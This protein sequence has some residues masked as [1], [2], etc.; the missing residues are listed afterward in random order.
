[1][2]KQT[3]GATT[4]DYGTF[5]KDSETRKATDPAQAVDLRFRGWVEVKPGKSESKPT[6]SSTS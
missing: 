4:D 6:S 3:T 1:M 2:A 5:E